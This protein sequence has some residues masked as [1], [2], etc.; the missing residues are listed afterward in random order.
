MSEWGNGVWEFS[1]WG[2]SRLFRGSSTGREVEMLTWCSVLLASPVLAAPAS[3]ISVPRLGSR[4][5][6]GNA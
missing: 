2:K 5:V 6:T 4:R 1:L 3:L